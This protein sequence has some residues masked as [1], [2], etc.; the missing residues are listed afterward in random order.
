MAKILVV[1]D[2]A[3]NRDIIKTRLEAAGYEVAEAANGEEGVNLAQKLPPDLIILDVMMPK[4]DGLLACRIL[5][6]NEK[7]K[8]IPIIMLTARSQQLEELRGWESGADEYLTKP[9]DHQH[10]LEVVSQ[11]LSKMNK[12]R[13]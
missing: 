10:L 4:V 5:K 9:C 1:D 8:G 2:D 7:T 12:E 13:L 11:F 6:S 3:V